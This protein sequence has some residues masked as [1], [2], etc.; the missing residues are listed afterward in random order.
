MYVMYVVYLIGSEWSRTSCILSCLVRLQ[1]HS[2]RTGRHTRAHGHILPH[3][4][5]YA[6]V[7]IFDSNDRAKHRSE[8]AAPSPKKKCRDRLVCGTYTHATNNRFLC[9]T[10][11]DVTPCRTSRSLVHVSR[12]T[13]DVT[14]CRTSPPM[15]VSRTLS[16]ETPDAIPC[17]LPFLPVDLRARAR[18]RAPNADPSFANQCCYITLCVYI[19]IYI[20]EYVYT[21]SYVHIN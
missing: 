17:R 18:R 6:H 8:L 9:R 7:H 10:P 14:P 4:R 2:S 16:R 15:P 12:E 13:P 20:Y 1:T 3:M 19:Y 5:T 11:L 21:Y